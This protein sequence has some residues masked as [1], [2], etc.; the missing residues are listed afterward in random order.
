MAAWVKVF[1][2]RVSACAMQESFHAASSRSNPRHNSRLPVS[3]PRP[4]SISE[5]I[6]PARPGIRA[7]HRA[8]SKLQQSPSPPLQA[9]H[10]LPH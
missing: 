3:R 5:S 7:N 8:Y 6:K 9:S 10:T 1:T 2:G 4:R